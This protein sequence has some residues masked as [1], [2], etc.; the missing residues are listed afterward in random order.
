MLA[1]LANNWIWILLVGGMLFMH[2]GHGGGHGGAGSGGCGAHNH[3]GG[4]TE[5]KA[6][7]EEHAGHQ[8]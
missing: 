6:N 1:F 3:E 5:L 7:R 4:T 2:R 8:H